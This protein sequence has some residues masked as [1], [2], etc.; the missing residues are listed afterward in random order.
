MP[1]VLWQVPQSVWV[2]ETLSCPRTCLKTCTCSFA[3]TK[4]QVQVTSYIHTESTQDLE[5]GKCY[6]GSSS[7]GPREGQFIS[8]CPPRCLFTG[9]RSNRS[10][11]LK[12]SCHSLK[13]GEW[14]GGEEF[15]LLKRSP[16]AALN[17]TSS[18]SNLPRSGTAQ[19]ITF[20]FFLVW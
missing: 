19:N 17:L 12:Q 16:W 5:F 14:K 4:G 7:V 3:Q 6:N 18:H 2:S 10:W 1:V 11:Q 13:K 8:M 9:A 20:F 15:Y